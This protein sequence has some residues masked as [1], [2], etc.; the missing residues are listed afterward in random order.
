M[1]RLSDREL[2][3]FEDVTAVAL[4]QIR[5]GRRLVVIVDDPDA[6][7]EIVGLIA[8]AASIRRMVIAERERRKGEERPNGRSKVDDRVSG[9][10]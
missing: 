1:T 5:R 3:F 4:R 6:L 8:D 7:D 2:H 9:G 10:D